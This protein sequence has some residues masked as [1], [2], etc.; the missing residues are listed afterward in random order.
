MLELIPAHIYYPQTAREDWVQ[1]HAIF[2]LGNFTVDN[3]HEKQEGG[4][5]T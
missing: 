4:D 5:F 2:I 1:W 3:I